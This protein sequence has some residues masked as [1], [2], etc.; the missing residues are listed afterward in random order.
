MSTF[1]Q[2]VGHI[3]SSKPK[4]KVQYSNF[5][6]LKYSFGGP[7]KFEKLNFLKQKNEAFGSKIQMFHQKSLEFG[8]IDF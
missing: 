4:K 7:Q 6:A 8:N 2:K 1:L 3:Q 5:S